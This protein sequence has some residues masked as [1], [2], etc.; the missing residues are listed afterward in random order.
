MTINLSRA[1]DD[2]DLCGFPGTTLPHL[3]RF[4]EALLRASVNVDQLEDGTDSQQ[5]RRT[6]MSL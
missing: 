2:M 3:A 5:A 1:G 4:T 6:R